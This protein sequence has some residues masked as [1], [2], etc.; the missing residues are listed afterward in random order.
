MDWRFGCIPDKI[1][2]FRYWESCRRMPRPLKRISPISIGSGRARL[3][4]KRC[5]QW[6]GQICLMYSCF[7]LIGAFSLSLSM[8]PLYRHVLCSCSLCRLSSAIG[9]YQH[10]FRSNIISHQYLQFIYGRKNRCPNHLCDQIWL[11]DFWIC[12][13]NTHKLKWFQSKM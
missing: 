2:L 5:F 6:N 8:V 4:D 1:N 12:K 11:T 13:Q 3:A 10:C 9:S 7:R